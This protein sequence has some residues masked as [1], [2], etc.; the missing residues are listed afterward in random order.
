LFHTESVLSNETVL[1]AGVTV[2]P[3]TAELYDLLTSNWTPTGNMTYPRMFHTASVFSNGV[4]L[5]ARGV[6]YFMGAAPTFSAELYNPWK[7]Y[8]KCV[9]MT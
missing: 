9:R 1:I 5:V 7:T 2:R 3:F 6:G 4:V 8:V